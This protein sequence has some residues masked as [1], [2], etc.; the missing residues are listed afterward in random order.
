MK[1][2]KTL[3]EAIVYFSDPQRA[4]DYAVSLRWPDGKVRCPRCN[5]DQNYFIKT[6][7]IWLCRGCNK[8]F[9]IKVGTIFE[10]SP[11]PLDKWMM[12]FWMLVNCKNGISSMEVHRALGITQ[13]SAWFMLQR[14]RLA[15][16]D[17]FFGSKLGGEV[18]VDETF[19][20]GKA[21]NMHLSERKRRITGTGMKDKTAV[22]GILERGGKVRTS[23][24][25]SRKK[26]V[27]QNEVRKH[28]M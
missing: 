6:R 7:R 19:I 24:V 21:R 12:A 8:Q 13:K 22:V 23:V 25:P 28:V 18:E 20:G 16:Q 9:T 2:P 3:Q 26:Q 14:L 27:L 17:D 5:S 15:M 10:D 11:L 1:P 4:F